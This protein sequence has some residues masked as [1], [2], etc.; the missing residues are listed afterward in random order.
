MT[1]ERPRIVTRLIMRYGHAKFIVYA[2]I[3]SEHV[4][5]IEPH[6]YV[7]AISIRKEREWEKEMMEEMK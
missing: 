2:L 1:R 6:Y 5:T 7:E 4:N 3:V